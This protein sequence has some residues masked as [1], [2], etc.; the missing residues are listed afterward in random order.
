[1]RLGDSVTGLDIR[2]TDLYDAR[3]IAQKIT[4]KNRFSL[5]GPGL[6][7]DEPQSI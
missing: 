6:D 2:V 3:N 1:M 4:G 7:A 5:L